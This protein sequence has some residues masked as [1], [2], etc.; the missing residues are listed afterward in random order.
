MPGLEKAVQQNL[1]LK[2]EPPPSLATMRKFPSPPQAACLCRSSLRLQVENITN[3]E[4]R[5]FVIVVGDWSQL[6]L[7]SEG[8]EKSR[9]AQR[10]LACIVVGVKVV[11]K[12]RHRRSRPDE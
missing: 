7:P 6:T 8:M 5:R 12:Y 10:A 3:C 9:K 11:L 1:P 2:K 4:C